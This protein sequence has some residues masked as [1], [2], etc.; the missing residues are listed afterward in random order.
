MLNLV[1]IVVGLVSLLLA[2]VAFIPLLGWANWFIIPLA[3]VGALIGFLSRSTTGRNL[4]LVVIV[5]GVIRLALGG[6]IF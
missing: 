2:V 4:N 6:G 5:I 3:M 1:S